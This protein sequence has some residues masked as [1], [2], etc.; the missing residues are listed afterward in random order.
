MNGAQVVSLAQAKLQKR[1][2][3]HVPCAVLPLI[4]LPGRRKRPREKKRGRVARQS[5]AQ[6]RLPPNELKLIFN[7]PILPE[8]LK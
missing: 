3:P 4:S 7:V 2:L 8:T 1:Q 6:D 5:G